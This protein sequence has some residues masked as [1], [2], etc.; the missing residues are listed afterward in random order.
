MT[1]VNCSELRTLVDECSRHVENLK[2]LEKEFTGVSEQFV[3]RL[4]ADALDKE[5]RRHWEC[6][7]KQGELPTY[8][9][10]IKFLKEQAFIMERCEGSIVKDKQEPIKKSSG[11]HSVHQSMVTTT[12]SDPVSSAIS[13]CEF[14]G[15]C[16]H[17]NFKCP[18]FLAITVAQRLLMVRERNVCFNCLRK[19]HRSANCPSTGTCAKCK[20]R[21]HSL[22][23]AETQQ[24]E[25][26]EVHPTKQDDKPN[27]QPPT[28]STEGSDDLPRASTSQV[29]TVT[30]ATGRG[31]L[32]PHVLLMT[33]VVDV[34]DKNGNPQPCRILLDSA[35]QVNIITQRMVHL[36]GVDEFPANLSIAGVDGMQ[37]RSNRGV[38][39]QLRS[40]YMHFLL[41]IQ[42]FVTQKVTADLPTSKANVTT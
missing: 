29:T 39:V 26:V 40:R 25:D 21:H 6:T 2:F 11:R 1:G 16:Q 36:L 19:G 15:D 27:K 42:C 8:D 18:Q 13:K 12:S 34:L 28:L 14:C 32:P 41:N 35:S 10:T 4:L 7:V 17:K 37:S 20:K 30:C 5:T 9:A 38:T 3:V 24:S 22:L 23:H 31:Q 33:A